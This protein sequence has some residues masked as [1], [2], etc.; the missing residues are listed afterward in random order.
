M[1]YDQDRPFARTDGRCLHAR[2]CSHAE[3]SVGFRPLTREQAEAFLREAHEHRRCMVCAPDIPEPPWARTRTRAGI[4][5]WRL[6]GVD[7]AYT[8]QAVEVVALAVDEE[9]DFAGWLAAVPANVARLKGGPGVLTAG[10]PGSWESA[11]VDQL[12]RGT[13]RGGEGL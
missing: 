11:L 13:V 1:T 6:P 4:P 8:R 2:D 12:V 10:R 3:V 9:C 7:P 5:R